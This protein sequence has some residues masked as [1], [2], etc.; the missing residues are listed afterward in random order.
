LLLLVVV[1]AV[2][3]VIFVFVYV[4][5]QRLLQDLQLVAVVD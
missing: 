1:V 3:E 5:L 2:L 4:A